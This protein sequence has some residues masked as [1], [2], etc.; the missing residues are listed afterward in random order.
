MTRRSTARAGAVLR[1][2]VARL[3][4]RERLQEY[5]VWPVW[6]EVVGELLASKAE[7]IRIEHGKLFVRVASSTWMQELQFLKEEI[8]ERLNR[9]VGAPIVSD[10]FFVLGR[11][12]RVAARATPQPHPVDESAIAAL[13]PDSGHADIDEALRR[14]ARARARRLGPAASA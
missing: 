7:P 6:T 11:V 3:E 2:L 13:V 4:L 5:S 8:R 14:V 9:R 1:D 12:K 10:L